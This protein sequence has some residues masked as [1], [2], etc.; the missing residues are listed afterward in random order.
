MLSFPEITALCAGF[1]G[2][3]GVVLACHVGSYRGKAKINLGDGDDKEL[4]CRI[5]KQGNYTE[6]VPLGLIV[7]GL[8]EMSGAAGT[9]A[10]SIMGG[11]LVVSRIL[12]P[13]GMKSDGSTS[14]YRFFGMIG[15]LPVI[16]AAS[17]WLI[18]S[19]MPI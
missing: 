13:L 8:L 19:Q 1:L 11:S 6:Y 15:T 17:I 12:H 3:L 7:L 16:L 9:M 14:M 5:R 4:F 10:I 18:I 2:V